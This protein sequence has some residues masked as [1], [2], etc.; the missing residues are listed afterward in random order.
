VKLRND[1][2]RILV[3]EDE[4]LIG[5]YIADYLSGIGYD[6]QGPFPDVAQ[7]IAFL[8]SASVDGAVLDI[9]L[10]REKSF[11]IADA[12]AE[13]GV[14]FVFLSGHVETVL[15]PSLSSSLLLTKPIILEN[16]GKVL[17]TFW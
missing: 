11:P 13:R 6:V 4:W 16:L 7:A 2:K 1:A 17:D 14:P 8:E 5:E 9:T 12:L 3:V 10:G 15:P